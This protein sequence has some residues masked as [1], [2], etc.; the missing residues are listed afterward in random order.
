M[1]GL[2]FSRNIVGLG[3]HAVARIYDA[4]GNCFTAVAYQ[5][6]ENFCEVTTQ[7]GSKLKIAK[8]S[9]IKFDLTPGK[10]MYL[11]DLEPL[12][13]EE[14]PILSELYHYRR[15]KNLEGGPLSVGRKVY[16]KGLALHS[17]TVLEYDIKGYSSFR[18]ILGL[19]DGMAGTAHAI[20]RIEG[21]EK[22]LLSTVISSR[23]NKPQEVLLNIRGMQR[24]R[25]IVLLS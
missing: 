11:S 5:W 20:V 1:R 24:L 12:K 2:Y 9:V 23:E 7:M 19:D 14:A 21:D 18:C 3:H 10:L 15:D 16:L 17:K 8:S 25:L 22:E 4:F 13:I 6:G